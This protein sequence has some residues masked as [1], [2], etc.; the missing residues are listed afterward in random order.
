MCLTLRSKVVTTRKAHRCFGCGEEW[1][2][3]SQMHAEVTRG[4]GRVYTLYLCDECHAVVPAYGEVYYEGEL[5][6]YR[7][8]PRSIGI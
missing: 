5:G 6:Q 1:P 3:G 7:K 4:D 2:A 8:D